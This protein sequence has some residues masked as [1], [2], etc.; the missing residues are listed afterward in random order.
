MKGR[1]TGLDPDEDRR[2]KA[3]DGD[4]GGGDG[5]MEIVKDTEAWCATVH[6]VEELDMT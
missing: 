5:W 4:I 3:G 2:L 6:G 1:P